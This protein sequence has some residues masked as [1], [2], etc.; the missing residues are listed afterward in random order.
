MPLLSFT[1]QAA[2]GAWASALLMRDRGARVTAALAA[3]ALTAVTVPRAVPRRQPPA[4]GPVLRLLTANLRMGRAAAGPL[5]EFA[6]RT[7]A[8]VLLVQELT[9]EAATRLAQAGLTA[10]LPHHLTQTVAAGAGGSGIYARHPLGN[11]LAVA[12][13]SIAQPVRPAA[14]SVR[15]VRAAGVRPLPSAEA[16]VAK[17]RGGQLARRPVDAAAAGRHPGDPGRGF[18]RHARPCAAAQAVAAGP[19]GRRPPG[20]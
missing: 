5:V 20:G 10:L 8:D 9:D 11:G 4:E 1:P 6:R 14:A 18:Q 15:T 12:P 19:P 2:A 16:A 3:T 7:G 13:A 17:G